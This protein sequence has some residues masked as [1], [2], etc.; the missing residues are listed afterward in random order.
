MFRLSPE[1]AD[2]WQ[3]VEHLYDTAFA[4]GREVL[5]S[6]RLRENVPAVRE[7]C[8]VAWN[9]MDGIAG[10]IRFW[11]VLIGDAADEALLLGPVA[12]H[13]IHQG[14]GLGAALMWETLERARALGWKRVVLVGDAPYYQRFGFKKAEGI[15]FP[16]PT[17]PDRL[18]WLPLVEGGCDGL[19]GM[20]RKWEGP[21]PT[22]P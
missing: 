9:E 1:T 5:S 13:P 20:I 18:L 16:P 14:E 21:V 10:A 4:P 19:S 7:L 3:E 17:N 2:D 12:I 22:W 15:D 8:L 11:P 6:Y